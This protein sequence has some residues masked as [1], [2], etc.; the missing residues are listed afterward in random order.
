[1]PPK[2]ETEKILG[3]SLALVLWAKDEKGED[4]VAVF[5]GT[6]MKEGTQYILQ[7]VENETNPM[8]LEEWLPRISEVPP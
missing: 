1:M 5:P 2:M 8:I 4:D 6:L 7:R 3:N